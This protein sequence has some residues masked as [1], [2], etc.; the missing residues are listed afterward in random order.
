MVIWQPRSDSSFYA[1][2]KQVEI[3]NGQFQFQGHLEFPR[4]VNMGAFD[5]NGELIFDTGWFYID[6]GDQQ[7]HIG[8][9][10]NNRRLSSNSTSFN[11]YAQ[12]FQPVYDSLEL[13]R[14]SITQELTSAR[15]YGHEQATLDSLSLIKERIAVQKGIFL[16]EYAMAHPGSFISLTEVYASISLGNYF[17]SE[18][19]F[20]FLDPVLQ[21]TARGQQIKKEISRVKVL[22]PG[23]R[24]PD[25]AL[26]N[27]GRN[28]TSLRKTISGKYTLIDFWFN[29]CVFC[30]QQFPDLKA[31]YQQFHPKGFEI[32]GITVDKERFETDWK[33]AIKTHDL[34]W[35]QYW[36]FDGIQCAEYLIN[37]FPTNFLLDKRGEIVGCNLTTSELQEFLTTKL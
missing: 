20:L 11:E 26:L 36:D 14:R 23:R 12:N 8:S 22:E 24:F 27:P 15:F 3:R 31:T 28:K 30:I 37:D 16:L 7:V 35:P 29:S 6:P 33:E 1:F 9:A 18:K 32:I 17:F 5:R 21:Q 34:P 2:E 13:L 19:A 25:F 10:A 4:E